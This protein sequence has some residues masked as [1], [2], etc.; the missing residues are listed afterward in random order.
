MPPAEFETVIPA[1]GRS[2][3]HALDCAPA[4]IGID[5]PGDRILGRNMLDRL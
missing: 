4:G 1:G 2:Q 5:T 3:N